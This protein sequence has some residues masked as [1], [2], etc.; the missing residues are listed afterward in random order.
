MLSWGSKNKY[1]PPVAIFQTN[2]ALINVVKPRG[3]VGEI[4]DGNGENSASALPT[5]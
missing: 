1:G 3:E 4:R 5:N 2:V